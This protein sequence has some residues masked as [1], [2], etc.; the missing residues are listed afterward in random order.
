MAD[1]DPIVAALLNQKLIDN[2]CSEDTTPEEQQKTRK[3]YGNMLTRAIQGVDALRVDLT[4]EER[5]RALHQLKGMLANFGFSGASAAI[6]EWERAGAVPADEVA[7]RQ[8]QVRALLEQS[9]TELCSRY[10]WL[11]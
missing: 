9:K 3:L 6:Q 4:M 11:A 7:R 1:P 10:P 8:Q 5:V 2:I